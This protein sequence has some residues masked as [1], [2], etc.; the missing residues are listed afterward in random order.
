MKPRFEFNPDFM[1]RQFTRNLLASL[2]RHGSNLQLRNAYRLVAVATTVLLCS[3][4][5]A[6]I[7]NS[8]SFDGTTFVPTGWTNEYV[9]GT[10]TNTWSRVTSGSNPTQSPHSG[11]GEAMFASYSYSSS[12]RCII[13]PAYDLSG[14]GSNTPTVSIWMYRDNGYSSTADKIDVM[15]NTSATQS[16]ATTLGTINRSRSLAPT[17]GSDGWYQYTFNVPAGFNGSTNYLILK[18][19]SQWGNNI[20]VDDVSWQSYPPPCSG[21]PNPGNTVASANPGCLSASPVLSLQNATSGSG[22][23]YQWQSS[24][25]GTTWSNISGATSATYNPTATAYYRCNVT[26]G[27]NTGTSSSLL[28][29][30]NSFI[31]C[32]CIPPIG[33]QQTYDG[34]QDNDEILNVTMGTLNN[35]TTCASNSTTYAYRDFGGSVSAPTFTIG[36]GYTISVTTPGVYSDH[37]AAWMDVNQNG[38]FDASEFISVGTASSS[39]P[40]VSTTWTIPAGALTGTTKM[41]VKLRYSTTQTSAT[42]CDGYSYGETQDYNVNLVCAATVTTQPKDSTICEGSNAAFSI[43]ATSTNSYQWQV[44]TNSGSTWTNITNG[45]VYSGATTTTLAITAATFSMHNYQY[46]CLAINTAG[47]CNTAS[48]AA[49]LK[50][51][52]LPAILTT[53]PGFACA[54]GAGSVSAT[55][56][57]GATVQWYNQSTGG[58]LLGSG[59]TLNIGTA[60]GSTTSYYAYPY[61]DTATS[62]DTLSAQLSATNSQ[63][64][65]F[66]DIVPTKN[67]KLTD[68]SFVPATSLSGTYDVDIYFKAGSHA[69]HETN[70]ASWTKIVAATGLTTVAGT[71]YKV[72][73][74]TQPNLTANDTFSILVIRAGTSGSVRYHTTTPAVVGSVWS[75]NSD[76]KLLV[77]KGI[78]GVFTGTLFNPRQLACI[79]WYEVPGAP[80]ASSVRTA[81]PLNINT[82]PV[83]SAHPVNSTVCNLANTSF[84]TTATNVAGYQWQ[85]ST[86]GGSTWGNVTNGGVYSNATT[87]TLNITGATT[88]MSTYQYRCQLTTSCTVTANTNPATLTVNPAPSVTSHPT[89]KIICNNGSTTFGAAGTGFGTLTFQWQVSTN[90]GVSWSNISNGGIYSGATTSTLTLTNAT[91]AVNGA[92]YRAVI[93]GGCSP[94]ANTNPATLTV[95][96]PPSITG[97]PSNATICPN[98]NTSFTCNAT[99]SGITYQWQVSTNGGSNWSN[100]TNGGV[101]SNA[102]TSTLN[103][104]SAPGTF[105]NYKYRCL[106]SG[107]CSPQAFTNEVILTIGANPVVTVQPPSRVVC[108]GTTGSTTLTATGFN[109][110]YQWEVSTN[111]GSSWSTITNG[112]FYAGV[113]TNTLQFISPTLGMSGYMYRCVVTNAC[114]IATT[115]NAMTLTVANAPVVTQQPA[116]QTICL[117]G[118][119]SYTVAATSSAPIAYQWQG[120]ENGTTWFNLINAGIY[121]GVTTTTLNLTS[122]GI[123]GYTMFRCVLNTGCIPAT[124]SNPAT[125]T[126]EVQP[127][128]SSNPGNKT[129][130]AGQNTYFAVTAGGSNLAY[131]WQ[132]S[133]N[134]GVSWANVS[135]GGVYSGATTAQ[136]TLT[137]VPS[138]MNAYRYRCVVSGSCP[139]TKT[140]SSA[141]LTVNTPVSISTNTPTS[142]TFCSNSNFSLSVGAT[143]T[144]ISYRWYR[145]VNGVWTALTNGG[146]YS[147]VTTSTLNVTNITAPTTTLTFIY[148][149]EISGTC[150][151]MSS[152]VTTVTVNAKPN[153]TLNPQSAT[154]CDSSTTL[155]FKV[156]ATGSNLSYQ[157]QLNTGSGWN[158]LINNSTYSGA[159]APTLTLPLVLYSMNGYQYRCVVTGICSPVATSSVATLTVNPLLTPSLTINVTND[160]IC[161]GTSVT[162]TTSPV[163]GGTSPT[164]VWKRNNTTIGTGSAF[165]TNTMANGDNVYCEMTSNATCATPKTVR[166]DNTI[167]MKVTPY[168]TPTITITSDVGTSWCSGKPAVFR[169][170]IT[171][172]GPTPTYEWQVNGQVVGAN[173]DTYM[174][175][176]LI[177]GDQVRCRLTS[178]LKCFTPAIVTSN[179][180]TMTIN[181]TTQSSIVIAPNPDSVIC[182]KTE[183]T[184]YSFFTNGGATPSFQWML[185]G[186]DVPGATAGTF[187]TTSL[188]SGDIIQCR[189]I[190]S[191]TCVFPEVSLPVSFNVNPLID[192]SVNVIVYYIGDET[193]RFT[194]IP[195]NGGLNPSYQWYKNNVPISGATGETYDAV[196]LSHN[197]R[198]HVMLASSEECVN[199]ELLQ[200]SSRTITT[201]VGGV[202]NSFTELGLYPNPNKGQFSIKGSLSQPVV[203]KEVTVRITNSLGQTVFT[204]AYNAGGNNIDLPVQLQNDLPNG[205]YQVNVAIDGNVTNLRFVLNR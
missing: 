93:T 62:N 6:Q 74:T 60:P 189:F 160:D 137:N 55:A 22:V 118:N 142:L 95:N 48:N 125:L 47:S 134:G 98:T 114:A 146:I 67:L 12:V 1:I 168:S 111:G 139:T 200:V 136:L 87:A 42:A 178:S 85:V 204:Q 154:R 70:A 185:N 187:K 151:N 5:N 63:R 20:F 53:T 25:N 197:D 132:L 73:L 81:V 171:N 138:T 71:P 199:P 94:A 166:S 4:V 107:S 19:T 97:Q 164:Y 32:Y 194:A 131:Q 7:T 52:Q 177:N 77:S 182:D 173:V 157:W 37:I 33:G 183:V 88:A 28:F 149:C 179:T 89:S 143:G 106:V 130:C 45:G 144:G 120:S 38:V 202:S 58:T 191:A 66:M 59:N 82:P 68:V 36:T 110:S 145:N 34:C 170:N 167:I 41:R 203:D 193:F 65:C 50:V 153:I 35:S 103:L 16:G 122:V 86:N 124:T 192:P 121:S 162:F 76:V 127:V 51:N 174:T 196:G 10:T 158:N 21:T 102:T 156:T 56:T 169:A 96:V 195:V 83:I 101:Y 57:A 9:S 186:Q 175:S 31:N 115:S 112:G 64:G 180:L 105:N 40:T 123:G 108:T 8:E 90:S 44:S 133:T 150:N 140:S 30:L 18:A 184:M 176:Q 79:V 26:C 91:T 99:G 181:Q 190:S 75:Q 198:I 165:T 29:T 159:N 17:V 113:T 13:T 14:R 3:N 72:T 135:N 155:N 69:G 163:N 46:R 54:G 152:N 104:T 11:A 148:R 100:V 205:M 129:I 92:W 80:C 116:N 84:S 161:A 61:V 27:V 201:G 78:S 2:M 109:N 172:G 15:I 141:S 128:I 39:T 126:I 119:T 23:T 49:T 24:P 117:D 43:A 188:S 147:G